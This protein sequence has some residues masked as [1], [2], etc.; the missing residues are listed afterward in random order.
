MPT[1]TPAIHTA[2]LKSTCKSEELWTYITYD[3]ICAGYVRIARTKG[4]STNKLTFT[5]LRSSLQSEFK[6]VIT[7]L[8][9]RFEKVSPVTFM[10]KWL[11]GKAR[12]VRDVTY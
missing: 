10:Q 4:A 2:L 9:L 6:A 1:A 11:P 7:L 5:F 8:Q 3:Y 12:G